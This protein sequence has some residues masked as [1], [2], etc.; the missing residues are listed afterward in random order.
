[1]YHSSILN[2]CITLFSYYIFRLLGLNVNIS[3]LLSILLSISAYPVSG[4]PFLD[5]HSSYFSLF[6][7]F[8]GIISIK[9]DKP[10]FWFLSSFLLCLAF[11]SKQVPAGYT[12]VLMSLFILYL[13]IIENKAYIFVYF[14]SGALFFLILLIAFLVIKK[15]SITDFIIQIFQFPLSIGSNRYENYSLG[16]KNLILDYK[17]IYIIFTIVI[18]FNVKEFLINK[19]L[20]KSN[21]NIFLLFSIFVFTSIFHQIYTKNQTYIFFSYQYVQELQFCIT[22]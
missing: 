14:V 3:L 10:F 20:D 1:M 19:K 5:L 16:F 6:A 21:L 12:I 15:I 8:F 4:T 9:K 7:I 11:F 13:T 22:I 2:T 17:F 18:I